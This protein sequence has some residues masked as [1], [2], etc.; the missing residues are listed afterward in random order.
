[1]KPINWESIADDLTG[2]CKS[3]IQE[4]EDLGVELDELESAMADQGIERCQLCDWWHPEDE[5]YDGGFCEQ[6]V[7]A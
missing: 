2:T 6:C 1:M 4:A 7:E 5:L 3:G